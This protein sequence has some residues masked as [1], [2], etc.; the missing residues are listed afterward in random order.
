MSVF[1]RAWL[2]LSRNKGKSSILLTL[3]VVISTLVLLC[4]SIGNAANT[5][6]AVLRER[7]GGY[8][9]VKNDIQNGGFLYVNDQMVEDIM[10]CGEIKAYKKPP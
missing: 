5:S 4:V 8:F 7:L 1:G 6:L 2:Y 10:E 9:L 3:L